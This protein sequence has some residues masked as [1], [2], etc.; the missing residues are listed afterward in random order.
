VTAGR[1]P[2]KQRI[3]AAVGLGRH[4]RHRQVEEINAVDFQWLI[5]P[6]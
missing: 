6:F 1:N 4:D 5:P 3:L 2:H